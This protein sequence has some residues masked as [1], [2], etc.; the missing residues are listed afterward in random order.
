M[1]ITTVELKK[2]EDYKKLTDR[3]DKLIRQSKEV[4]I[5]I[6]ISELKR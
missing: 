2:E 1:K 4:Y 5:I 3:L 6:P